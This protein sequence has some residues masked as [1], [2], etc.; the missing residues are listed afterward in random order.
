MLTQAAMIGGD[1]SANFLSSSKGSL[2]NIAVESGEKKQLKI[3]AKGGTLNQ[4]DSSQSIK[5]LQAMMKNNQQ[6]A[7][8]VGGPMFFEMFGQ[9]SSQGKN[10]SII[11]KVIQGTNSSAAGK[12]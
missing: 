2:K 10:G 7:A 5:S 9:S 1:S 11:K 4:V 6:L 3:V 8:A 12:T